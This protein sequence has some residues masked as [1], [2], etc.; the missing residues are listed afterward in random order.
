MNNRHELE[1]LG[2][3]LEAALDHVMDDE[4]W[5]FDMANDPEIPQKSTSSVYHT[6]ESYITERLAQPEPG[7]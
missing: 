5:L 1:H 3:L 2:T 4:Q 7:E 6:L